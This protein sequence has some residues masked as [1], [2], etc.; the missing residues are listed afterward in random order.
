[1]NAL[2]ARGSE[3]TL[4][5]NGEAENDEERP[6]DAD[7]DDRDDKRG[8]GDAENDDSGHSRGG[9]GAGYDDERD[10]A[11]VE[12]SSTDENYAPVSLPLARVILECCCRKLTDNIPCSTKRAG[13]VSMEQE[14][15]TEKGVFGDETALTE[16]GRGRVEND[17]HVKLSSTHRR[18]LRNEVKFPISFDERHVTLP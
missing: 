5:D 4:V 6:D 9:S 13:T 12:D 11:D 16:E 3:E 2:V 7:Q 8:A 18:R 10:G 15:D 1:M 14:S 17:F